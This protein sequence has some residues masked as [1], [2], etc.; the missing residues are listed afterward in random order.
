MQLYSGPSLAGLDALFGNGWF[1]SAW[2][3]QI[4]FVSGVNLPM[5]LQ[6]LY[7]I[8][9]AAVR[10]ANETKFRI[11]VIPRNIDCVSLSTLFSKR[12]SVFAETTII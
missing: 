10:G 8:V 4:P 3:K 2:P 6:E 7:I 5:V 11:P 1:C 12:V 9:A